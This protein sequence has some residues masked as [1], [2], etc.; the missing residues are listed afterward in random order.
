MQTFKRCH[1]LQ[2]RRSTSTG[3]VALL[4]TAMV[5]PLTLTVGNATSVPAAADEIGTSQTASACVAPVD[6]EEAAAQL[7]PAQKATVSAS[8]TTTWNKVTAV[9]DGESVYDDA[10]GGTDQSKLWGTYKGSGREAQQWLQYQWNG[11]VTLT[12]ASVSFYTNIDTTQTVNG[13]GMPQSWKLQVSNDGTDWT[14][15]ELTADAPTVAGQPNAVTFKQPVK[16]SY[17]RAVFN[18]AELNGTYAAVGVS[19]F[20]VTAEG[21]VPYDASN[22]NA[23]LTSNSFNF[24]VSRSTGGVTTLSNATDTP[25]CTNYVINPDTNLSGSR[26][27]VDDSRWVGDIGTWTNGKAQNT[28]L[29]DHGRTVTKQDG[30]I[31]VKYDS[32]KTENRAGAIKDFDLTEQYSLSGNSGNVLNWD[33]TID[34]TSGKQL[35]MDDLT[36]PMLMNSWWDSSSQD[37]IYQQNVSR[38]AYVAK[39]GSYV[40]WQRPNG[41]GPYLVMVPK[42]GTSLEFKDKARPGEGTFGESDPAWEGLVELAIHSDHLQEA[43]KGK[44]D[45]YLDSS[46]LT[47]DADKSQNYGFTFRWASDYDDLHNVLYEA[48]VVDAV[49]Y[50][51]YTVPQGQKATLAVRAKDGI[52][53]ITSGGGKNTANDNDVTI[54]KTGAKNGYDLYEIEFPKNL[55]EHYVTVNFGKSGARQSVIQYNSISQIDKLIDTH[56]QF[57]VDNQQAKDSSKGY[58]GAFL[59][60]S[61]DRVTQVT[62]DM[63]N[64]NWGWNQK[65]MTGGSDDLGLSP[66]EFLAEKNVESPVKS[67][68]EAL[69]YYIENFMLGYLQNEQKK[70]DAYWKTTCNGDSACLNDRSWNI[71]HWY[72]GG[73][74]DRPSTSDGLATWR[75]MNAPHVWNTYYGMYRIAKTYPSLAKDMK[76]SAQEYLQ[77]AYN[78]AHAYY[79]HDLNYTAA[80]LDNSARDMGAMGEST[81]PDIVAALKAEGK[82]DEADMLTKHAQDKLKVFQSKHYPFASEMSI[83]TTAFESTYT[84]SKFGTPLDEALQRKTTLASLSAR[85]NQPLWYYNGSD[86]RH[87]GESWWNLG[88][89]TQLGAWQQQDYLK[90]TDVAAQGLDA[91]EL[92]RSTYGAYLAG[93][94]NINMGQI[95]DNAKNIGAAAWQYQ[96]EG[97]TATASGGYSYIPVKNHWWMWSGEADL[98]FWGALRTASVNVVNDKIIGEYAYGAQLTDKDNAYT[99]VPQDGVE[100][101]ATFYNLNKLGFELNGAKYSSA[102]VAKDSSSLKLTLKNTLGSGS[103]APTVTLSNLPAGDWEVVSGSKRVDVNRDEDGS[104]EVDLSGLKLAG[105]AADITI[106]KKGDT[107]QPSATYLYYVD[108]GVRG[109]NTPS[110]AYVDAKSAAEFAGSPLLNGKPDQQNDGKWGVSTASKLATV[111]GGSDTTVLN[112]TG[113]SIGYRFTLPAGTYRLTAGLGGKNGGATNLNQKVSWSGGSMSG[114][115]VSVARNS[116]ASD[117]SVE[118]TL[119]K[120]TTVTYTVTRA[121]GAYPSLY[122]IG[123][124]ER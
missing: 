39:D 117:A 16:A 17:L 93:W 15:V 92:M 63:K 105:A 114:D 38:H 77:M 113:K 20:A 69:D 91:D 23:V 102:T 60:W 74:G 124:Q 45:G 64:V 58:D 82:A 95:D 41:E 75:T 44:I 50:P 85:G 11:E 13:V 6:S 109:S 68:I 10:T 37:N 72:D 97:G 122:W 103:F 70:D 108:A 62:R 4:A 34:N 84:M 81:V 67:Q 115:A 21:D 40:Y 87:M 35:T 73:D 19:E 51:G 9:Q 24:S 26:F 43:R 116:G 100:R 96:S 83:D 76:F 99:I 18:A 90:T 121:S 31:T 14:D 111:S 86:N 94:S 89:E 2:L 54:T 107:P 57:L 12:G 104:A 61:M 106:Q 56:S 80:A 42:A 66:A 47:L 33:I 27:N 59:Q 79:L 30:K 22:G 1:W 98:G 52:T 5:V 32:S 53:S 101:R 29:S 112:A 3:I 25:S 28:S 36:L 71:Y 7:T 88:Y 110:Q 49:S 55:G 123:V 65:W 46:K 119:S 120:K 48:G 8:Y 78:T 118:F